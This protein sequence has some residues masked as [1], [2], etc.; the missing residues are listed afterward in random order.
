MT[1]KYYTYAYLTADRK[2]YYIGKG[3][4][5]RAYYHSN[6]YDVPTPDREFILILKSGLTEEE[7]WKHEEYM[8][9][10]IEGLQNKCSGGKGWGGGCAATAERKQKIGDANRGRELSAEHKQKVSAAQKGRKHSPDHVAKRAASASRSITLINIT[11][12]EVRT[13]PSQNDCARSLNVDHSSVSHLKRGKIHKLKD[14]V[15][16]SKY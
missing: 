11:T 14:W 10:V 7:A 8:I 13:F 3:S 2:P 12:N 1:S 15:L 4:G 9:A 16:H 5:R 6:S